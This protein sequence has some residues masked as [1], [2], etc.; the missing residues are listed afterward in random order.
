MSNKYESFSFTWHGDITSI[1]SAAQHARR[2]IRPLVEGGAHVRL[3]PLRVQR[4]QEK[5][6]EW[7]DTTLK[8]CT[9]APPG[10]IHINATSPEAGVKNPTGGPT[11]LFTH[12]ETS[13]PPR[14]WEQHMF[15]DKYN[16]IWVPTDGLAEQLLEAGTDKKVR[17][18]PYALDRT[19]L[20]GQD[21]TVFHGVADDAFVF[22]YTGLWNNRKNISDA[23]IAYFG[24]F[25][26]VDNV[27]LVLKTNGSN[28][29]DANER[30]KILNMI[31]EIKKSFNKHGHPP[32][33][34]L[35]D[36][37]SQPA[38]DSIIRSFNCFLSSS[39]GE[40]RNI[41]M[42][43][44]MARG[45]PCIYTDTLASKDMA[46]KVNAMLG[47][48]S[49]VL[50]PVGY[51]EE[52]VMQ[53]GNYYTAGDRWARPHCGDMMKAMRE[54]Y[55]NHFISPQTVAQKELAATSRKLFDKN[56]LPAL[57]KEAQPFAIQ[58]LA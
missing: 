48:D 42:A 28:P 55:N 23:I 56:L 9:Q 13:R 10:L 45:I 37:F 35:Q 29:T 58:R 43:K 19:Y 8:A 31:K 51:T 2:V 47:K 25:S 15:S 36:V 1:S 12:W 5:M 34:V 44:A 33:V 22:G 52:P 21:K 46:S 27:A 18:L 20:K 49:P 4:P 54:V 11:V 41:T 50:Y 39:R 53:M 6:S 26:S 30:K 14:H 40:G 24:E 57:L 17:V 38:M 3:Q 32:V 7:W 16:E